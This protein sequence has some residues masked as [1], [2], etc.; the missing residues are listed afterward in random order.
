KID[1][2]DA[3]RRDVLAGVAVGDGRGRGVDELHDRPTVDLTLRIR[4][5]GHHHHSHREGGF[6][7]RLRVRVQAVSQAA[8]LSGPT[9]RLESPGCLERARPR[10]SMLSPAA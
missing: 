2:V 6:C 1:A 4:V 7:N 5:R 8:L 3:R 9:W 10:S